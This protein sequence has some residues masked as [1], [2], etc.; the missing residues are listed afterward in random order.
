MLCARSIALIAGRDF[1]LPEDVK[2]VASA[3]LAHRVTVK[4]ELWMTAVSGSTVMA[5]LLDSVPAPPAR[6]LRAQR[7][8]R[9][10][11]RS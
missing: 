1:V 9:T 10:Q 3:V 7:G 11:E 8:A 2:Q 4:P 6:E 5:S